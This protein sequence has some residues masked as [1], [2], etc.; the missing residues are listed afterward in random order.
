ME[1]M[2]GFLAMTMLEMSQLLV[3]II[4]YHPILII[5]KVKFLVLVEGDTFGFNGNFGT[6]EKKIRIIF[7][8]EKI[9]LSLH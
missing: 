9:C 1:N 6:Q 3:L 5:Q 2:S 7:W 8:K 4:V